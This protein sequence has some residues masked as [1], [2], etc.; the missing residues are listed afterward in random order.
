MK[1]LLI[2]IAILLLPLTI[3]AMTPLTDTDLSNINGQAGVNINPNL[4]MD[5]NIGTI[6][7]GDS[8]GINPSSGYNPWSAVTEGGYI[9]LN[10]FNISNLQIKLRDNDTYNGYTSLMMKPITIDVATTGPSGLN[11]YTDGKLTESIPAD[12]TFVRIGTGALKISMDQ[13]QFDVALGSHAATNYIGNTTVLNQTLGIV[14]LAPSEVYVNPQSYV[15]V[16]SHANHGVTYAV[17]VTLDQINIPYMS[18]GDRDGLTSGNGNRTT[19]TD[20]GYIGL[21]NFRIGNGASPA[22]K[23]SGSMQIDVLTTKSGI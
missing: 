3:W 9:G 2:L 18:W 10:D 15:D 17:N 4:T 14:S 6:A 23:A 22:V 19:N 5:I 1:S 13:M 21:N 16:Y 20:A 7:W 8:D 12:T 11:V